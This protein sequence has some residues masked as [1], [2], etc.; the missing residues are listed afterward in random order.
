MYIENLDLETRNKIY[1][2]TKKVLRKYQ[3][4][5]INGKLTADNFA[6]NILSNGLI[7]EI[8]EENML[9][10]EEFKKSYI[11][12]IQALIHIQNKNFSSK[13]ISSKKPS[14]SQKLELK[15]MLDT[16]DYSLSMPIEYLNYNEVES[17]IKYI[18]TDKIEIGDEK[19]YNYVK[20]R[21]KSVE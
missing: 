6:E 18:N 5:I 4:G 10:E 8:I 19:I 21:V 20:K 12:Y 9:T 1:N 13:D 3:K 15:R 17:I 14:I 2:Q 16:G 7:N 11:D